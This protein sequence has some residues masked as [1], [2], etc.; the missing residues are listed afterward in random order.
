MV[1][2]CALTAALMCAS[3]GTFAL[4]SLLCRSIGVNPLGYKA[5]AADRSLTT[6]SYKPQGQASRGPPVASAPASST[7]VAGKLKAAFQRRAWLQQT[8]MVVAIA[9]TSM[10]LGDGVFT[11]AISGAYACCVGPW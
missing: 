3:G 6:Y 7:G 8:L 2:A 5:P 11:P 10:V 9:A 4:F 1:A